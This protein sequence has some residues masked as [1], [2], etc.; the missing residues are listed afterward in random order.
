MRDRSEPKIPSARARTS[1]EDDATGAIF[2]PD[3]PDYAAKS[4]NQPVKAQGCK[5]W[6]GSYWSTRQLRRQSA[7]GHLSWHLSWLR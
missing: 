7:L 6:Q 2:V 3:E 1:L 5:G 4:A